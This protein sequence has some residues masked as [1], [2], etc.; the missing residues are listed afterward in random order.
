M[1][2]LV[3][4]LLLLMLAGAAGCTQ[5]SVTPTA[6]IGANANGTLDK[7]AAGEWL[8]F[9]ITVDEAGDAVGI[10]VRGTL[11]RGT[12][13]A[14]LAASDGQVVWEEAFETAGPFVVTR[15]LTPPPGRYDLGLVWDGPVLASYALR[16]QP[17]VIEQVKVSPVALIG[18]LGMIFVAIGYGAYSVANKLGVAY[19]LMGALSWGIAVGL[20]F[21]WAIPING[22]LLKRLLGTLPKGQ[23]N[24]IFYVYVGLLTGIFEVIPVWLI[25]RYTRLGQVTW[26]KA[27]SFGIGFGAVEALVLG[28]SSLGTALVA[29]A[30]PSMLPLTSAQLAQLSDI[31]VQVAPPVERLSVVMVHIATNMLVFYGVAR[32]APKWFWLSFAFKSALDVLAAFGQFW[33]LD[34]LAKIW[35]IEAGIV[36]FG[37]VAWIALREIRRRYPEA[38]ER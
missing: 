22:P 34:T 33:G 25:M 1:R 26:S 13:R 24:A 16:W 27:L 4:L 10:E 19:M 31:L 17:G 29:L 28:I 20:K 35:I 38:G 5:A 23:A 37:A 6:L 9:G 15:Q 2:R 14:R 30:A 18:G 32:R 21:A 11:V 3:T 12:L 7:D 36:A 8:P